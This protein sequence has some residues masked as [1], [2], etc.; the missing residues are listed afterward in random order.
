[1]KKKIILIP[2]LGAMLYTLLSSYS[3]GPGLSGLERTGASGTIGCGGGGCHSTGATA[4]TTL[5]L[6]LYS[7]I[8][9]VPAY[10]AGGSYTIRI[11][12]TQTSSTLVLSHFG[13]QVAVVKS[14]TTTNAGT[15]SAVA[16]KHLTTVSGI[17]LVE[18]SSSTLATTGT[19]GSGTTYV[20]NIPWTAPVAGTGNVTIFSVLNAVN[21]PSGA[22]PGDKWNNTSVVIPESVTVPAITGTMTACVGATTTLSDAAPGGTWSSG[23]PSIATVVAG[24]GVVTGVA[25]GTAVITY[26]SGSSTVTATVTVNPLPAPIAGTT[27]V[28]TGGTTTLTDAT[29]PGGWISGTPAVATV[30][31]STGIVAGVS[32]GTSLITYGLPTGCFRTTTVTVNAPTPIT[33]PDTVCTGATITLAEATTGG[34]WSSATTAVATVS[35]TGIVTG[36]TIGSSV[37]SYTLPGGCVASKT[38]MVRAVPGVISGAVVVCVGSNITVTENVSGGVW[39]SSN[40]HATI[41]S[42]TGIVTGVTIGTDTIKYFVTN[43]CGT[44]TATHI[45]SVHAAGTCTSGIL[46]A[47]G[48]EEGL[49]V[50]PNPAREGNFTV[51]ISSDEDEDVHIVITNIVGAVVK[52]STTKTNINAE[53]S[54]NK[55]PGIYILTAISAHAK[56]VAKVVVE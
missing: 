16:G 37:I 31:S 12:G 8:T 38:I 36:V 49:K 4:S 41:G 46:M 10:V 51:S 5:S 17:N 24:T 33:G 15:L 20:V 43:L 47:G 54:L 55:A 22:D 19:G 2:L 32:T 34:T 9:P 18:H 14:T 13:F 29:T 7:G 11:T 45:I 25:A 56:Y 3:A 6:Q 44:G 27:T 21:G 30:G 23:S 48:P 42:A 50:Y 53:I 52:E 40:S 35:L 28:C 26:T 1:M 39:S